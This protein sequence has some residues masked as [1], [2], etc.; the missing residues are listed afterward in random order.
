MNIYVC[1][2]C[3]YMCRGGHYLFSYVPKSCST[4]FFS[5]LYFHFICMGVLL[6]CMCHMYAVPS[7]AGKTCQIPWT[8][9]AGG[10]EPPCVYSRLNQGLLREQSGLSLQSPEPGAH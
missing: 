2:W 4:F 9:V 8:R 7:E 10:Y 1:V 5:P 3:V 6:A